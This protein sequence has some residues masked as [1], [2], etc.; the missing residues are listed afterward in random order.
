VFSAF[1]A[2]TTEKERSSSHRFT[3]R[4]IVEWPVSLFLFCFG[5]CVFEAAKI[6]KKPQEK[7]Q[8]GNAQLRGK[9]VS[10]APFFFFVRRRRSAAS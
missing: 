4:T 1:T 5:V 6:V 8:N 3:D 9:K 10:A 2:F 7:K